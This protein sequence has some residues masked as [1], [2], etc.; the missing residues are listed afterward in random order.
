M[1]ERVGAALLDLA[2]G[3]VNPAEGETIDIEAFEKEVG[4]RLSLP[5]ELT[6][7]Y[8]S[9]YFKHIFGSDGY[10]SG[11]YTYMWAEVLDCD[12][13][14]L[15]KEKVSLIPRLLHHSVGMCSNPE[16]AKTPM[17]LYVRFR[18]HEP[19]VGAVLRKYGL[20]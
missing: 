9:P 6:Y 10:A 5:S 2:Y 3:H 13:Y 19:Q 12:G 1:A 20:N 15:F 16:A 17:T 4:K 8:R 14:E 7:R 18:G 11:Y